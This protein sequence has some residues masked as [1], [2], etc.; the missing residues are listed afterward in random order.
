MSW[1]IGWVWLLGERDLW[2]AAERWAAADPDEE[3]GWAAA[4]QGRGVRPPHPEAGRPQAPPQ[5]IR[6]LTRHFIWTCAFLIV[7]QLP[8]NPYYITSSN[9]NSYG[10]VGNGCVVIRIRIILESRIRIRIRVKGRIRIRIRIRI[11]VKS[12]IRGPDPRQSE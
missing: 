4:W 10:T 1:A 5:T 12:R 3:H 11:K 9:I 6:Y 8:P 2:Q 7:I